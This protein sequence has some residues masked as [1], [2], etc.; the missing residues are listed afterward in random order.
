MQSGK[1]RQWSTGNGT[2]D[3]G[4]RDSRSDRLANDQLLDVRLGELVAIMTADPARALV[5]QRKD[6]KLDDGRTV[7]QPVK[8][9]E[10]IAMHHVFGVVQDDR[11]GAFARPCFEGDQ[12][13][14][15][16]VEAVR[17]G[18]RP[19]RFDA[20]GLHPVVGT[21]AIAAAV[22]AAVAGSFR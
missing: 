6:G 14:V 2:A 4:E 15:K 3:A 1:R 5:D 18:R 12:G 20:N 21:P 19:V 17:L 22:A 11:L 10:L 7:D 8:N 9:S 16:M 13:V